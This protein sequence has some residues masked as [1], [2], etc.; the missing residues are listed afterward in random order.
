MHHQCALNVAAD[1]NDILND[2]VQ[3]LF[4]RYIEPR[5][6]RNLVVSFGKL[7]RYDA[8]RQQ[9]IFEREEELQERR[10][11][12]LAVDKIS[13]RFGRNAILRASALLKH[14]TIIDRHG[15]IGGHR[16]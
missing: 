3:Q 5:P 16:A 2:L 7:S 11:L 4:A 1:D 9:S 14:S 12:R 13:E 15:L 8:P 10:C 6:I